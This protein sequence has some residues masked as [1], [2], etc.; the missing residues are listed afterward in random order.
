MQGR[1]IRA[2]L[3]AALATAAFLVARDDPASA[4]WLPD[5]DP[6]CTAPY[7]QNGI[8]LMPDGAGGLS[9]SARWASWERATTC[10]GSTRPRGSAPVS[11]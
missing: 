2:S 3:I 10:C 6:V 8:A 11:T 1:R 9:L 7:E 5:G 4:Q